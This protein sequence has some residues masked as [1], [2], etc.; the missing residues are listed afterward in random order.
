MRLANDYY[1]ACKETIRTEFP[2]L[3]R[4]DLTFNGGGSPTINLHKENSPLNDISSGSCLVKPTSFDIPTLE[5]YQPTCYIAT[6]V[7][8]SFAGTTLPAM[9]SMKAALNLINSKNR[10]SYFIYG[11]FWKADYCYPHGIQQNKIYGASTNQTMLNAPQN[12]KLEIDDFVFLR[13]QQ[14]E[15]VFLQFGKLLVIKDKTIIKEW[16]TLKNY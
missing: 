14:S 3:W 12:A 8:K 15:F 11:G 5:A 2:E 16:E 6:P 13:P 7:L 1:T 10:N 9:E 4:D